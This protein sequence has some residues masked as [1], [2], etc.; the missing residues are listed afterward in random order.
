MNINKTFDSKYLKADGDIPDDGNLILTIE[1]VRLESVG[2]GDDASDKPVV[3]FRETDKGLVLNKT[4]ATTIT[5]LYG[6][7]TDDWIGKKI[8]LFS[9]E[10]D[11]GG[12]QVLA[13]RVRMKKPQPAAQPAPV[14]AKAG[15][16]DD[17]DPF[18]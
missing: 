10:V 14:T 1:V 7:E 8:A 9:T 3:Y 4:N 18:E 16:D 15:A 12:K 13:I 17:S 11:F 6:P 2:Q 5:G